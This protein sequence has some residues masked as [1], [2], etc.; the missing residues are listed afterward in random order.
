[1]IGSTLIQAARGGTIADVTTYVRSGEA[2]RRLGVSTATLY[3]YV[4]RG[5]IPRRR[6][7]DGRTSLFAVEDIDAL[8]HATRRAEPPPRP[9]IDVQ[10]ASA[11]T[12]LGDDGITVRGSDLIE[13]VTQRRFEDVAELLLSGSL[14]TTAARWPAP[15]PDDVA[16][17][18]SAGRAGRRRRPISRLAVAAID[19][20]TLH[21]IDDAATAAR[22]LLGVTPALYGS[23]STGPSFARRLAG[24]W[25]PR[26][27]RALVDAVDRALGLLADHELATST[28]A[29]RVAASV[30]ASPLTAFAAGLTTL[31]S[32][33]HGSAAMLV[34]EMIE[35]AASAGSSRTV[36]E[37]RADRRRIPGLG[38]KVYRDTDPRFLPLFDAVRRIDARRMAV[39]DELFAEV[40]RTVPTRPNVDFALGALTW[41][42]EL[43]RDAPL[44]AVARIAGWAAH[45][46]EELTEPPLRY[47]GLAR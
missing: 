39:V 29:V 23:T 19:L 37:Y 15:A 30:R 38:H 18:T 5:R 9:T 14:P 7:A 3:A 21:A 17:V 20:D 40:T 27:S 11:I 44:F 43:P 35:Q 6:A 45:Y 24:A 10:I 1:L 26:P 36:A 32:E 47:R 12:H 46:D 2:A 16:W 8:L 4:S 13:L 41:V 22:R 42:A 31:D 28:I 25:T 33:L 34:H